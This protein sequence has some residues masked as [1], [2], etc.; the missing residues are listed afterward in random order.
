MKRILIL[1]GILAASA[2]LSIGLLRKPPISEDS[3]FE[4]LA[5]EFVSCLPREQ[6]K[7]QKREVLGILEQFWGRVRLGKVARKD[8]EYVKKTLLHYIEE[9]SIPVVELQYFMAEVGYLTYRG[10]PDYNL[11]NGEVDHPLLNPDQD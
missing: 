7:Q 6:T 1:A 9:G 2:V 11:P 3:S 4:R 8:V 10:D 5:R